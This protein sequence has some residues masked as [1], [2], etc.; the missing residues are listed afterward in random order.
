MSSPSS[1]SLDNEIKNSP[2]FCN[3]YPN[4]CLED[5]KDY[6]GKSDLNLD[7]VLFEFM[8][9]LNSI[10]FTGVIH[11]ESR[12]KRVNEIYSLLCEGNDKKFNATTITEYM[13][14]L[15]GIENYFFNDKIEGRKTRFD[16]FL[17][18]LKWNKKYRTIYNIEKLELSY[19]TKMGENLYRGNQYVM[20]AN[21]KNL[22]SYNRIPGE[23][24]I[25]SREEFEWV[26]SGYNKAKY[27]SLAHKE[28][29]KT[30]GSKYTTRTISKK[31]VRCL[32]VM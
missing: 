32:L 21:K 8:K 27:E 17:E 23:E 6:I 2:Y 26:N 30:D 14:K 11:P 15:L 31:K 22:E 1:P 20:K 4:K 9:K 19:I 12:F 29:R 7:E 24:I 28:I 18:Y 3:P 5:F 25:L 13:L 16:K 10:G